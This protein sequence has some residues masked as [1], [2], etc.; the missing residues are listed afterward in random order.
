MNA[1][2]LVNITLTAPVALI[3]SIIFKFSLDLSILDAVVCFIVMLALIMLSTSFALLLNILS[4]NFNWVN[5]A[6]IVKQSMPV[7]VAM[8]AMMI[9]AVGCMIVA[10]VIPLPYNITNLGIAMCLMLLSALFAFLCYRMK[11]KE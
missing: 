3:S 4:P 6:A 1:K 10:L 2:M 7:F 11:I 9:L 8:F 5:E